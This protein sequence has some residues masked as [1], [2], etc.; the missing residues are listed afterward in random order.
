[1]RRS[2]TCLRNLA[3]KEPKLVIEMIVHAELE[4]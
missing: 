1:L 4:Q 2:K 3:E